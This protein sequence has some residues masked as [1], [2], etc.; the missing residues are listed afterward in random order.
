[1]GRACRP[2]VHRVPRW[3]ARDL[4]P[5]RSAGSGRAAER[6]WPRSPRAHLLH[7]AWY[8]GPGR[9][10][11]APE[12]L[13]WVRASLALVRSGRRCRVPTNCGIGLLPRVR[14]VVRLLLRDADAARPSHAVR[15]VQAGGG[16]SARGLRASQ[17]AS[18]RRGGGSSSSTVRTSIRTASCPAS[19]DRC[20]RATRRVSRTAD[21]FATTSTLS[22]LPTRSWRCSTSDI[23]GRRQHRDRRADRAE[24]DRRERGSA[25]SD[26]KSWSD[27]GRFPP[28]RPT[29]R[30]SSPTRGGSDD[31]RWSPRI[32]LEDGLRETIDWWRR[33]LG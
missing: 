12:N 1:M 20:S 14:L 18:A 2:A 27:S 19:S 10:A 22:T 4:A 25:A 30:S 5:M 33:N 23:A 3:L 8:I 15:S 31:L 24:G 29:R 26:A 6:S 17:A 9:W 32:G 28:R 16:E 11:G 21:R 7:L 13:A